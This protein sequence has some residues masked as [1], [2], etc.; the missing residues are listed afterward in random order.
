MSYRPTGH[1]LK[2]LPTNLAAFGKSSPASTTSDT[3][4]PK[5]AQPPASP[6]QSHST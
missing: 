4:P 5:S 6:P 3:E 1:Q 2:D